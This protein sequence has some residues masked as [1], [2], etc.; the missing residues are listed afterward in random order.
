MGINSSSLR[1]NL[2]EGMRPPTYE[3]VLAAQQEIENAR[4]NREYIIAAYRDIYARGMNASN[5]D[6]Y[7][8]AYDIFNDALT[9]DDQLG[10]MGVDPSARFTDEQRQV[11]ET[12]R[13]RI[14]THLV[15]PFDRFTRGETIRYRETTFSKYNLA[16]RLYW[17][18]R[19]V[20]ESDPREALDK[21]T[22]ALTELSSEPRV[23]FYNSR[24]RDFDIFFKL[25]VDELRARITD[26]EYK[27][28]PLP[29]TPTIPTTTTPTIPTTTTPTI[30]KTATPTISIPTPED[31]RMTLIQ[32]QEN[33]Q[34]RLEDRRRALR[35]VPDR[36]QYR[37]YR[38]RL[39][40]EID[41]LEERLAV[42][43]Q[44]LS[45]FNSQAFTEQ[46]KGTLDG[47]Y[48]QLDNSDLYGSDIRCGG[49]K[50][51]LLN[52]CYN[53]NDCLGVTTL[54]DESGGERGHCMK[55]K[56][57]DNYTISRG[58]PEKLYVKKNITNLDLNSRQLYELSGNVFDVYNDL[59]P[60][61][62]F[63]DF[64]RGDLHGYDLGSCGSYR[65]IND[66]MKKCRDDVTCMAVTKKS[67]GS[68][69]CMKR[70]NRPSYEF[71][72]NSPGGESISLKIQDGSR[73]L[74]KAVREFIDDGQMGAYLGGM[75][76]VQRRKNGKQTL[77]PW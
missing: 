45:Q 39:Q 65:D 12:A 53:N 36:A 61:H 56:T 64:K 8:E 76:N 71:D 3:E 15:T 4:Q 34:R 2:K 16:R 27:L 21:Y 37:N 33:N 29:Q 48:I 14:E 40:R 31:R 5:D 75:R 24:W 42:I 44:Q 18:G 72:K 35:R 17:D 70:I 28:Y 63:F 22:E 7:Q 6:T 50:Y 26:L 9:W 1:E 38:S 30:P 25:E 32:S 69:H 23:I 46:E 77:S 55:S 47:N 60:D 11:L 49:E 74:N 57:R 59:S 19:E 10:R 20:E 52:E 43:D 68:P 73:S 58:V 51:A 67:D 13:Q 41:E 66:I 62:Y 54:P